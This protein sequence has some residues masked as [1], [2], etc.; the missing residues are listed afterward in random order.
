MKTTTVLFAGASIGVL[1]AAGCATADR[2]STA[3]PYGA[4]LYTG[5]PQPDAA[6]H[7]AY[8][9]APE[10]TSANGAPFEIV[11]Y[12][13]I[14]GA[15]RAHALYTEAEAEALDGRCEEAVNPS[16][17]ES[18]IDIAELCDVPLDMLVEY[19]PGVAD[20]SYATSGAT[21]KIPGGLKA[22]KGVAAMSDQLVLLD[23]VQPGDSLEKIA[24]RLNISE[25]AIANLNPGVDWKNPIAGQS[26]VRPAA[27]PQSTAASAY[28][29]PA[30]TPQW[31]GY[32]GARGIAGS[33]AASAIG[34]TAH[35]PYALSPVKSYG[36]AAG[37]YPEATL[38]VDRKFVK[39]GGSV[40]VTAKAAPGAEVTFYSGAE[41]GNLAKSTT[42]RADE[43]GTATASIKVKKK[44]NMGG[45]VFGARAAGSNETQFSDRVGV[46]R[47]KEE[48]A[49]EDESDE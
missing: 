26:F 6:D 23:T 48:A 46:V 30:E 16:T 34:V 49:T 5:A 19:N 31:E 44:S 27:A 47:L 29:P 45:V 37:V 22:P 15:R 3:D 12:E 42:V 25:A 41:P 21:V 1:L 8:L 10:Q 28:A 24:Y 35:A 4:A 20:I 11:S 7:Y 13:G 36:R 39:A 18:M 38:A 33:E 43:S 2:A 14:E 40:N 17:S 32:D 9:Y